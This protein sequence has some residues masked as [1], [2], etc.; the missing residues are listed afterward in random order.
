METCSGPVW[1]SGVLGSCGYGR[2]RTKNQVG[3]GADA[4][5]LPEVVGNAAQLVDPLDKESIAEG[6]RQVLSDHTLADSLREKGQK[7][8]DMFTWDASAR[9]L[10]EICKDV[11]GSL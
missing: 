1:D 9:R 8:K 11:L 7:Q 3:T 4:A 6:I 2:R 5:S 10:T